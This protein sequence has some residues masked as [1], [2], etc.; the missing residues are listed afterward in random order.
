M[1]QTHLPNSHRIGFHYYPDT[2]HF[3]RDDLETWL[4]RLVE[5][6][7]AWLTVL[8]P[9]ERAIP[10]SFIRGVLSAGIQPLL[11]FSL[12]VGQPA[13]LETVRLLLELYCPLGCATGGVL[14]AAQRPLQLACGSLGQERPGR[15]LP[16]RFHPLSAGSPGT[17]IDG[18]HP[19]AGTG[20]RLLGP[21][22]SAH[23]LAQPA[24]AQRWQIVGVA[25]DRRLCLDQRTPAN[26]GCRRAGTL[27]RGAAVC[28]P[29]RTARPAGFSHFRLVPGHLPAGTRLSAASLSPARRAATAIRFI[30]GTGPG[31]PL[32]PRPAKPERRPLGSR[33]PGFGAGG[34]RRERGCQSLQLLAA[35]G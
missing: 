23:S 17:G 29:G 31:C 4:P 2:W 14:P 7:A 3:R 10:E 34:G 1:N 30:T 35:G 8:A 12:P 9:A 6:G 19:A 25:G 15:A 33:R 32:E 22:I 24:T 11:H 26:L 18:H 20:R 27:A 13:P 5:L 28:H 16:G 21:I